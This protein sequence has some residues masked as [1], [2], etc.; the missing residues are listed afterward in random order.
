VTSLESQTD[1]ECFIDLAA[2]A[3]MGTMAASN[4]GPSQGLLDST[5]RDTE[6]QAAVRLMME[7]SMLKGRLCEQ[8]ARTVNAQEKVC[9]AAF[10]Q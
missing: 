4:W 2:T 5:W 9:I 3:T 8:E 1:F 7:L 6:G 10:V